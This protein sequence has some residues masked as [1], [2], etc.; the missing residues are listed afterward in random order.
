MR[1]SQQKNEI[2]LGIFLDL[3]KVYDSIDREILKKNNDYGI[4]SVIWDW[5]KSYLTNRKQYVQIGNFG[6]S[7]KSDNSLIKLGIPQGSILEPLLFN[8]FINYRC[9]ILQNTSH[10]I[11]CY[12][13][14]TSIL[15]RRTNVTSLNITVIMT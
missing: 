10:K 5:I 2:P 11:V 13:N 8:I 14:D 7:V 12:A 4:R 1:R 3:T 6:K 15:L 9:D